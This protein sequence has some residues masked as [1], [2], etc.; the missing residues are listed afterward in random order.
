VVEVPISFSCF[1]GKL[2]KTC[3]FF[4]VGANQPSM[5]VNAAS[6]VTVLSTLFIIAIFTQIESSA[7]LFP[8][9]QQVQQPGT[10]AI[11]SDQGFTLDESAQ[12]AASLASA[13]GIGSSYSFAEIAGRSSLFV[14][15]KIPLHREHTANLKNSRVIPRQALFGVLC[16]SISKPE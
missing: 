3:C 13:W 14:C 8:D 15:N 6:P 10:K 12:A 2:G 9:S 7:A 16:R 11:S 1:V 5:A 4:L